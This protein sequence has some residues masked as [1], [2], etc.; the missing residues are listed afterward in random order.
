MAKKS[1]PKRRRGFGAIAHGP[2]SAAVKRRT[3]KT[4]AEEAF[5]KLKQKLDDIKERFKENRAA[6]RF[7]YKESLAEIYALLWQWASEKKLERRL[8][9]VAKLHG[10]VRRDNA[11]RFSGIVAYCC[12]FDERRTK[13]QRDRYRRNVSRWSRKLDDAFEQHIPPNKLIDFL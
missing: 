8:A 13:E 1:A 12:D 2:K 9:T 3:E 11:N 5:P 6:G 7:E 10:V 4:A